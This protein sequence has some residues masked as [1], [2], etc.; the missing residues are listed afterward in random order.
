M[1]RG[2]TKI[3]CLSICRTSPRAAT[4]PGRSECRTEQKSGRPIVSW[5]WTLWTCSHLRVGTDDLRA[6]RRKSTETRLR[7]DYRLP[8]C[9]CLH[10]EVARKISRRGSYDEFISDRSEKVVYTAWPNPF[11]SHDSLYRCHRSQTSAFQ[12]ET[13]TDPVHRCLSHSHFGDCGLVKQPNGGLTCTEI[14]PVQSRDSGGRLTTSQSTFPTRLAP[15]IDL[16][17]Y[18]ARRSTSQNIPYRKLT[19]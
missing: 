3:R 6:A 1:S 19:I 17:I 8:H 13:N 9:I 12:T 2:D 14:S 18:E 16:R 15:A 11:S 7:R 4:F 5:W 10:S